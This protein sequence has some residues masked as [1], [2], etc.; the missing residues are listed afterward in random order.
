[1]GLWMTTRR[2]HQRR[3][4]LTI[5]QRRKQRQWL[6]TLMS[7]YNLHSRWNKIYILAKGHV[8]CAIR[9]IIC[10]HM[11]LLIKSALGV[12]DHRSSS[13]SLSSLK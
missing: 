11:I 12:F 8:L 2:V 6:M 7:N 9:S 10:R 4:V 3:M 5:Q 1:M 13:E